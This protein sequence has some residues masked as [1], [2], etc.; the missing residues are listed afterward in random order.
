MAGRMI[1]KYRKKDVEIVLAIDLGPIAEHT[2][3]R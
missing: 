3:Q 2:F 1:L